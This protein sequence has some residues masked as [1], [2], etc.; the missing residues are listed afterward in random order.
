VKENNINETN[1]TPAP[2]RKQPNLHLLLDKSEYSHWRS[3]NTIKSSPVAFLPNIPS[4]VNQ[5]DCHLTSFLLGPALHRGIP[6]ILSG[7]LL[8]RYWN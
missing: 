5:N 4:S 8:I 2:T 6:P 7:Y 3:E 1:L